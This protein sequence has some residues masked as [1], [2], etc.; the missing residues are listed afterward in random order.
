VDHLKPFLFQGVRYPPGKE[1]IG[2]NQQN[3]A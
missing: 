2:V 1:D 3:L